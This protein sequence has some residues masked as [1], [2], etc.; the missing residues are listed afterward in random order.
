MNLLKWLYAIKISK[1]QWQK[2]LDVLDPAST[3]QMPPTFFFIQILNKSIIFPPKFLNLKSYFHYMNIFDRMWSNWGLRTKFGSIQS[4]SH[5]RL[6]AT[7]WTA[8][9]Q[10]S[11]SITNS[12]SSPKPM[13]IVSVMPSNHLIL[14]H[15][16][17]LLPSILL[18]IRVFSKKL[19]LHIR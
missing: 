4:L 3:W 19:A 9:R 2:K 15:P 13:S 18:S 12:W 17:L 14:C 5:V 6:F 11:L 8:A 1:T 16:L 10:A 7:P